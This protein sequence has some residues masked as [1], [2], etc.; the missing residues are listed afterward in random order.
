METL[1][2]MDIVDRPR[3]VEWPGCDRCGARATTRRR[4]GRMTLDFCDHHTRD[5]RITAPL[6]TAG[7]E[8]F[9]LG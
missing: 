8:S 1:A 4:L 3:I 9:R 6:N 7:W 2:P 5:V